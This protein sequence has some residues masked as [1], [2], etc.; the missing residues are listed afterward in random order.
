MTTLGKAD[1]VQIIEARLR[2]VESKK[3]SLEVDLMVENNRNEPSEEALAN[4]N[5]AITE[6]NNQLSVLNQEL[7]SVNQLEE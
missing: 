5:N 3:Y 2:A 1:K 6:C 4:I 7:D